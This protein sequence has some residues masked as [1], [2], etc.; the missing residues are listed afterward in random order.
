MANQS[1][2][3]SLAL[4]TPV[5]PCGLTDEAIENGGYTVAEKAILLALSRQ[6]N[7]S[8]R[9]QDCPPGKEANQTYQDM[10]N[11]LGSVEEALDCSGWC[12]NIANSL[13]F[14]FSSVDAGK[15]KTACYET[16]KT[17]L[18]KYGNVIGISAFI[19]SLFL[20]LVCAANLA[21]CCSPENKSAALK[22]RLV[23]NDQGY[24]RRTD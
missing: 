2:N 16:M 4:C 8:M 11:L 19:A 15:P 3:M 1:Y 13:F 10:F 12:D 6:N 9:Y 14:K 20:L 17:N 7:G 24:Y 21:I 5:C 18:N 23:Y 22:D